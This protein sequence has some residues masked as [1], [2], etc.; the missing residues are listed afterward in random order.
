MIGLQTPN[1]SIAPI[2]SPSVDERLSRITLNLV[3]LPFIFIEKESRYIEF[4]RT[5]PPQFDGDPRVNLICSCLVSMR[6]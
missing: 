5:N 6:G 1:A 3:T 4:I 2:G